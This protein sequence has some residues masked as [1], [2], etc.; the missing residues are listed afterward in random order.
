M[1]PQWLISVGDHIV[2]A[3]AVWTSRLPVKYQDVCSRVMRDS[4]GHDVWAYEDL[5][6]GVAGVS[7]VI[8]RDKA[9][10][11]LAPSNY[12]EI[13]PSCFDPAALQ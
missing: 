7:A 11:S 5:R 4:A 9:D 10:W 1:I 13:Q 3:P 6:W 8:G 12:D 2:E